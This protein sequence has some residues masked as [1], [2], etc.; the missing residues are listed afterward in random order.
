MS[1]DVSPKSRMRAPT[2][3]VESTDEPTTEVQASKNWNISFHLS[4]YLNSSVALLGSLIVHLILIV[5]LARVV[6]PILKPGSD[7]NT[8]VQI[9][10][11]FSSSTSSEETVLEVSTF[12]EA[13][14]SSTASNIGHLNVIASAASSEVPHREPQLYG[15]S[16][17]LRI[18]DPSDLRITRDELLT[19]IAVPMRYM[20]M[21]QHR[22]ES[23]ISTVD[24]IPEMSG[25]ISGELEQISNDGDAIV[26]W[27]F[28]QSLSMQQDMDVLA[29]QLLTTFKEIQENQ[30]TE[31]IHHVVAFGNDAGLLQ[32]ST[33]NG[34]ATAN[35]IE[36]LPSD[37]SGIENTFQAVEWC[38]DQL[39]SHRK[40]ERFH[41]RQKL[42]IL[43]T[44]ESGDDYLRMENTIQKCLAA[45]VRVDVIGPSA[46]LGAQTGYTSF[47]HPADE[48]IYQLPVHRGPD[49][50]F[51][52][53]LNL[54]YWFR[55]V[56][57][58]YREEL[59]G[60]YQGTSPIWHGGSNLTS[61]L[62]GF[63]PYAL[64]RLTRQTGGRYIIYDRPGD[65]PPFSLA[66]IKEYEPD[67][68]SLQEIKND[69]QQRPLRQIVL[70][71]SAV[72]WK[73]QYTG[74][75]EPDLNFS[76]GYYGEPSLQYQ[77]VSLPAFVR[78][79][80]YRT[81]NAL[82][83]VERALSI[84]VKAA[85]LPEF[86]ANPEVSANKNPYQVTKEEGNF[87]VKDSQRLLDEAEAPQISLLEQLY[88][89]EPSPRWRA[90]CDLNF[91]R[92]LAIS[93]RQRE[94]LLTVQPL[95]NNRSN[96]LNKETNHVFLRQSQILRGGAVSE[97]RVQ[98][99]EKLLQRCIDEN[100]GTPWSIM[101]E[102]ELRDPCGFE[103]I[104]RVHKPPK[105]ASTPIPQRPQPTR[106]TLPNL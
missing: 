9:E 89:A 20:P 88:K 31:M 99:A 72:T 7:V 48:N 76:R 29:S 92:L 24:G 103:L 41:E 1:F 100:P 85:I 5:I 79:Q 102:R 28:D 34:L 78:P 52:Q 83:D 63:S 74:G 67:Y 17:D 104:Q 10:S 69:I 32:N 91:G 42:L 8:V 53:K 59:R 38:V 15:E 37:P 30:R 58:N 23:R 18:A 51:P 81:Y 73:S 13:V 25:E 87:N 36:K 12:T 40:W 26:V 47:L 45:N 61:L 68:R 44:D 54:G 80:L 50:A 46:V 19:K 95:A 101:A 105:Q 66:E 49:S 2:S 27:L 86:E 75:G 21:H 90:W 65:R 93:V 71:A 39:F 62:S 96:G 14:A 3:N 11:E 4:E 82:Q 94:Y 70:A 43:W 97:K 22:G 77:T 57:L 98:I 56:P 106:P 6:L 55:G 16:G 64:T 35:A 33:I 60:P 84:Y